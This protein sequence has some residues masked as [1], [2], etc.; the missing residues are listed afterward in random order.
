MAQLRTTLGVHADKV[1]AVMAA[2]R[3][4]TP[5][6]VEWDAQARRLVETGEV[7][8]VLHPSGRPAWFNS[9]A[10]HKTLN[11]LVQGRGRELLVDA[12]LRWE[13]MHPGQLIWPIHDEIVAMVPEQHAEEWTRDLVMC[14][15][16]TIGEGDC[17]VPIVAEADKPTRRWGCV[18]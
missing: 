1:D 9:R 7:R 6:L 13:Q 4:L 10:P 3:Q 15:T 11:T 16:T 2:L 5:Q 17:Q 12:L 18:E 8:Y 14:M